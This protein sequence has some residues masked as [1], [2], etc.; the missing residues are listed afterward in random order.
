MTRPDSF[1]ITT[2]PVRR[3]TLIVLLCAT[4][5]ACAVSEENQAPPRLPTDAEVEQYNASVG[6][7]EKIICREE[8]GVASNIPRRV[9]RYVKDIEDLGIFTRGQLRQV[10]Q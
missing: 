4:A 3:I 9:C 8:R 7:D 10:L 2:Y 6:P 1:A 5:T